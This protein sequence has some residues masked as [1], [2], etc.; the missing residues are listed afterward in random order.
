[1]PWW[2]YSDGA[3]DELAR[4]LLVDNWQFRGKTSGLRSIGT[5]PVFTT[6]R[7]MVERSTAWLGDPVSNPA[8][9]QQGGCRFDPYINI[10]DRRVPMPHTSPMWIGLEKSPARL[11]GTPAVTPGSPHSSRFAQTSNSCCPSLTG[12]CACQ[13]PT[14]ALSVLAGSPAV[15][16]IVKTAEERPRRSATTGRNWATICR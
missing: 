12:T 9:S 5:R 7:L 10:G 8:R 13:Q 2:P 16:R 3:V 6:I 15:V 11:L 4:T 14:K 1:V